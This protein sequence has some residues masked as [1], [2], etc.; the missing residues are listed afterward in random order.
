MKLEVQISEQLQGLSQSIMMPT[1][2]SGNTSDIIHVKE[3]R[4][5]PPVNEKD[6]S[7]PTSTPQIK[8]VTKSAT[9]HVFV[10]V[11]RSGEDLATKAEEDDVVKV[12][13]DSPGP[14]AAAVLDGD[15]TYDDEDDYADDTYDDDYEEDFDNDGGSN[16]DSS[17]D[18]VHKDGGQTARQGEAQRNQSPSEEMEG[19]ICT[20]GSLSYSPSATPCMTLSRVG[21]NVGTLDSNTGLLGEKFFESPRATSPGEDG[22]AP[23][24]ARPESNEEGSRESGQENDEGAGDYEYGTADFDFE[25]EDYGDEDFEDT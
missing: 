24:S 10:P 17:G 9:E 7:K 18:T 14:A 22:A 19:A 23:S 20:K 5:P 8:A 3:N 21:S 25:E 2:P 4:S 15:N 11:Q 6:V 16:K 12:N 13:D 1:I